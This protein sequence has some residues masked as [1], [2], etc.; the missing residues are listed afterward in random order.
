[1]KIAIPLAV[2]T[3]VLGVDAFWRLTC[4][5]QVGLARVDPLVSPGEV[6]AHVHAIHGSSGFN[7]KATFADITA[8]NT[9]TSCSIAEDKSVYWTPALYFQDGATGEYEV[10][11]QK[12]G[13][14]VY[15]L[16]RPNP[17]SKGVKAFP[18]G[19]SMIAGDS[20]RRA[21]SIHLGNVMAPDPGKSEWSALSQ[22]NQRD[23]AERAL[24]FNCLH[25]AKEP[26]GAL[27]R[28][29]LPTKDYLDANCLNGVRFEL[30]FPSCWNGKDLDSP[31]HRDHMAYPDLVDDGNC[32]PSHP[33]RMISLMY[34]TI[35]DTY[36]F[37]GRN[38]TFVI[39][40]G[41]IQGYGYHGDFQSGWNVDLLQKAANECTDMDGLQE[42]CPLFKIQSDDVS[43]ACKMPIPA[44][45]MGE[46]VKK[47]GNLLP[48]K[49]EIQ[50]GPGRA[51][52]IHPTKPSVLPEVPSASYAPGPTVSGGGGVYPP[53][54]VFQQSPPAVPEPSTD[55]G[56]NILQAPSE[57]APT[58][59]APEQPTP[60]APLPPAPAVTPPP[61][62]S[63]AKPVNPNAIRTEYITKDGIVSEIVY[64]QAIV[65]V[66]EDAP[67]TNTVLITPGAAKRLRVRGSHAHMHR[68][69]HRH[70]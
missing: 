41:D 5:G 31:N 25:Y 36:A 49:V 33:V 37:L 28:H 2:W 59:P 60:E 34:E 12:G 58:E 18:E 54:Q 42:R 55:S 51:T 69:Q 57:P 7:E 10:V 16:L 3:L 15:Y 13:M 63:E 11:N 9:C 14:L 56:L 30:M 4:P 8:P 21:Y 24:G 66:T 38:G 44:S 39:A 64:E 17:G 70:A 47:P 48:G 45:L 23:L 61:V 50:Y 20:L 35:W 26:E 67:V 40:N 52:A 46:E 43:R 62:L 27:W 53:G 1:M 32:P 68:H 6:S 19:F 29:F 22:T 65:Y